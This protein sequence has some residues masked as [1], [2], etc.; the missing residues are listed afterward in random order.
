[1]YPDKHS[2][3][4]VNGQFTPQY[5]P[6]SDHQSPGPHSD[7]SDSLPLEQ[8]GGYWD[9]PDQRH[10][11]LGT[12]DPFNQESARSSE[13]TP[14][15]H[16]SPLTSAAL[17]SATLFATAHSDHQDNQPSTRPR[18]RAAT[19]KTE[20]MTPIPRRGR[21][22]SSMHDMEQ[23]PANEP[24]PSARSSALSRDIDGLGPEK[25]KRSKDTQSEATKLELNRKAAH[26]CR[27]KKKL[28]HKSLQSEHDALVAE[29]RELDNTTRELQNHIIGLKNEILRHAN[30]GDPN[31]DNY[32][33]MQAAA[34]RWSTPQVPAPQ[35]MP[36]QMGQL[37]GEAHMDQLNGQMHMD[38]PN[39]HVALQHEDPVDAAI[40][41]LKTEPEYDSRFDANLPEYEEFISAN[42]PYHSG[43]TP[44]EGETTPL[45]MFGS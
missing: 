29:Q 5:T 25:K 15:Q 21:K 39:G 2:T 3:L 11:S 7:R 10:D 33:Q 19:V 44:M 16:I 40:L 35:P 37:N 4:L 30:C 34:L 24:L 32:L 20:T 31:I 18:K 26:K 13:R 23:S 8:M 45:G 43:A 38:R 41:K 9:V 27:E 1:M 12:M 14:S 17:S 36:T 42:S 22:R 28:Q 6:P